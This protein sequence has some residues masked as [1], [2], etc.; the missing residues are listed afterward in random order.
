MLTIG[1]VTPTVASR[2][3]VFLLDLL[4][5]LVL[6]ISVKELFLPF[7]NVT[8][9]GVNIDTECRTVSIPD[10]QLHIICDLVMGWLTKRHCSRKQLQS[11]LGNLLYIHKRI[12]TACI[13]LNRMLDLLRDNYDIEK[14]TLTE[15]FRRDLR[16]FNALLRLDIIL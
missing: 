11:L 5:T 2:S 6:N 14:I 7:T 4:N 1:V 8:C 3:Y 13:F 9:L 15:E 16:W 10:E 12:K